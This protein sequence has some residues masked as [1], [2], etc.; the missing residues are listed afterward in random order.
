MFYL[1]RACTPTPCHADVGLHPLERQHAF[2]FSPHETSPSRTSRLSSIPDL[3]LQFV[4]SPLECSDQERHRCFQFGRGI[5]CRGKH[6]SES[7]LS[8]RDAHWRD[9]FHTRHKQSTRW[10]DRKL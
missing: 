10:I 1:P 9:R 2:L 8:L 4:P 3:Q 6:S 5:P 7:R